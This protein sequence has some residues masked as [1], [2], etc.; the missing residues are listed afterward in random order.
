[1]SR[2]AESIR[3]LSERLIPSYGIAIDGWISLCAE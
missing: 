2:D 3:V 1:M